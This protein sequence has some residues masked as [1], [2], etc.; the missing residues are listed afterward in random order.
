VLL[1]IDIL[2]NLET[3]YGGYSTDVLVFIGIGWIVI[4]LVVA[5][6]FT[7]LKWKR[8]IENR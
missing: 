4:T 5:A 7:R 3:P 8:V 2:K 6:I 1:T